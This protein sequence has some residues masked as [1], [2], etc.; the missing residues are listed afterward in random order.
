MSN[1]PHSQYSYESGQRKGKPTNWEERHGFFLAIFEK[2]VNTHYSTGCV[3][4]TLQH[5]K[6]P[7][8]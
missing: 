2:L 5:P 6:V 8:V 1:T 7:I 3:Q 4:L